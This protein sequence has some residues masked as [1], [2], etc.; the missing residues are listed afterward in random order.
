MEI[1]L[2]FELIE[3]IKHLW[4]FQEEVGMFICINRL[5]YIVLFPYFTNFILFLESHSLSRK[6][7]KLKLIFDYLKEVLSDTVAW[8]AMCMGS[9]D[10]NSVR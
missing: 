1:F 3:D 8:V 7:I 4:K 6:Y 9:D 10:D 2:R 5:K